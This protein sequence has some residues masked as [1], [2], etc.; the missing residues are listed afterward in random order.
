MHRVPKALRRKWAKAPTLIPPY[1][2]NI[3]SRPANPKRAARSRP[4]GFVC[5]RNRG[6]IIFVMCRCY[7]IFG[8]LPLIPIMARLRTNLS[9]L[10]RKLI[11]HQLKIATLEAKLTEQRQTIA[12]QEDRIHHLETERERIDDDI[13]RRVCLAPPLPSLS[14]IRLLTRG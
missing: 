4:V 13:D 11:N 10:L 2:V 14:A 7:C 5:T 8:S 12:R 1:C 6:C 3:W 9:I